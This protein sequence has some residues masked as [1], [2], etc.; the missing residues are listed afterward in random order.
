MQEVAAF[1]GAAPKP[2]KPLCKRFFAVLQKEQYE[3]SKQVLIYKILDDS[4]DGGIERSLQTVPCPATLAGF[5]FFRFDRYYWDRAVEEQALWFNEGAYWS[6]DDGDNQV[7]AL[8]VL[9]HFPT[10]VCSSLD[11]ITFQLTVIVDHQQDSPRQHQ[12]SH[13]PM[14]L[15]R[16]LSRKLARLPPQLQHSRH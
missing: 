10:E 8:V 15:A 2:P 4:G 1:I 14:S 12:S 11:I 9:D 3:N 16:R 6:D 5:F 13:V 7:Y